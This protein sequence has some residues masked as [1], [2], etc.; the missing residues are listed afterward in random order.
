MTQ[1]T[2]YNHAYELIVDYIKSRASTEEI[3]LISPRMFS[4]FNQRARTSGL[5]MST[6]ECLLRFCMNKEDAAVI[7][8]LYEEDPC[9][10]TL[11]QVYNTIEML[12]G[13]NYGESGHNEKVN[14][15]IEAVRQRDTTDLFDYNQKKFSAMKLSDGDRLASLKDFML[16]DSSKYSANDVA[17]FADGFTSRFLST[18]LKRKAYDTFFEFL[19]P[20]TKNNS[21]MYIKKMMYGLSPVNDLPDLIKEKYNLVRSQLSNDDSFVLDIITKLGY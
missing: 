13:F 14:A 2:V 5:T 6:L 16:N 20:A 8:E 10:F 18:D 11:S 9:A 4:F 19:I 1:N 15:I 3:A 7:L 12:L 17:A 21:N